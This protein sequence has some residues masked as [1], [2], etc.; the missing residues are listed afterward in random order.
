MAFSEQTKNLK[1]KIAEHSKSWGACRSIDLEPIV[2][3]M[4]TCFSHSSFSSNV[5]SFPYSPILRF[6]SQTLETEHS[7]SS[8]AMS[9]LIWQ[10]VCLIDLV[11]SCISISVLVLNKF[12]THVALLF[13]SWKD[14]Q[15]WSWICNSGVEKICNTD[16]E[17]KYT[18][19]SLSSLRW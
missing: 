7:T 9:S 2:V 15:Q 18:F 17:I 3:A 19:I 11:Y 14:L 16:W 12:H 10:S 4:V 13:W 5:Y 1:P 6:L 8:S